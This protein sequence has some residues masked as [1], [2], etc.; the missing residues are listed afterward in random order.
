MKLKLI[1]FPLNFTRR[2]VGAG[3]GAEWWREGL[4][5]CSPEYCCSVSM[6]RQQVEEMILD[7]GCVHHHA[8]RV[9]IEYKNNL[10]IAQGIIFSK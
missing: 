2:N 7:P 9:R 5:E 4:M 10:V 3:A 1:S 8:L 6:K